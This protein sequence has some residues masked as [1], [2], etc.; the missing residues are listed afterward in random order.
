MKLKNSYLF[1]IIFSLAMSLAGCEML[2]TRIDTLP[3]EENINT[4]YSTLWGLGY[5]PYTYLRNGFSSID[6]NLFA[7]VSDEAEQTSPTSSTQLFNEGSWNAYRNPANVYERC[8]EGIRATN[9]FLENSEDYKTFLALNRDTISDGQRQYNLD[10]K[11][12]AW[13]R[14]ESRVLRAYFYFELIKRYGDVPLVTKVLTADDNTD[15]TR[16]GFDEVVDFIVT[17]I[18]AVKNDLQSDWASYDVTQAGR[19]TQGAALAIKAR[20]LLYAASPL[21]NSSNDLTKWEKAATAAKE[22]ME[23]NQYY[24]ADDY[25]QLF[26]ADNTAKSRETIWALRLG[27][28]NSFEIKNYPIATPGGESGV[29]PAQNLVGAYEYKGTPDPENPYANRDPRLAYSIVTNNSFW[30]GRTME[31]WAGGND[32]EHNTNASKTGYYLKKFLNPNLN[33]VQNESKLR[34]WIVFRYAEV[35]LNYAEAMNEAF[36]PDDNNGG[37]MSARQAVNAVR[38][39]SGVEM[40]AVDADDQTEMRERIK[41]ERRIELAFEDHRY[42]DLIRWKDAEE[43]LSQPL[44]GIKVMKNEDGSFSYTDFVVENRKF[45]SPK[46]YRFPI[47]QVE[48][49]KSEGVLVQNPEW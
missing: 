37:G 1:I 17:E 24:L 47:P 9:F 14:N 23:L 38:A 35:L 7:A 20:T 41:H 45:I 28:N 13:L 22:L 39:R 40:P 4:N 48:I 15:L 27:T 49:S 32:D 36:G 8:Y 10:V 5:A 25:Q 26:V 3:T 19:I 33:L 2:D 44:K 29:T 42:W 18:D 30:N 46:M 16:T 43:V 21:N 6:G 11:D 12:I 34:S 31:I